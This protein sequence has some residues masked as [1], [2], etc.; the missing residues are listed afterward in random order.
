MK[1]ILQALV[2]ADKVYEEK[3]GKKIIAGT[4]NRINT[5]KAQAQQITTPG[6]TPAVVMQG[7]TDPGCP[8]AYLSLTDVFDGTELKVQY[9]DVSTNAM[10]FELGVKIQNHDRLATIEIVVPLPHMNNFA[11]KPGTYSL[12][13]MWK[14][15]ILGSHR[16]VVQEVK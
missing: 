9:N 1:P 14:N 3:T 13:V 11:P 10:I 4:F 16:V 15:E 5:G 6:G 8:W 12:D 2:L 7:G